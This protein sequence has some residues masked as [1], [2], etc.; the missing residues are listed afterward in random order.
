MLWSHLDG[1]EGVPLLACLAVV[2]S[3]KTSS[4]QR[5]MREQLTEEP[6]VSMAHFGYDQVR[7]LS[8]LV[9]CFI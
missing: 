9:L 4:R 2:N 1:L 6:K 5:S 8:Y 7:H 3:G